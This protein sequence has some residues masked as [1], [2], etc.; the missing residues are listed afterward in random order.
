MTSLV[1]PETEFTFRELCD[2]NPSLLP[3]T[4]LKFITEQI[5]RGR[6]ARKSAEANRGSHATYIHIP[7]VSPPP[8]LSPEP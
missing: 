3:L 8:L 1:V 4:V 6:L 7:T 5:T 2:A